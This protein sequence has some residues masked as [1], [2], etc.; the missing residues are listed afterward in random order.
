MIKDH[1]QLLPFHICNNLECEIHFGLIKLKGQ[2]R[3]LF[4]NETIPRIELNY[5]IF[6]VRLK[7]LYVGNSWIYILSLDPSLHPGCVSSCLLSG[8]TWPC[9]E[10]YSLTRSEINSWT[11]H[12]VC[13]SCCRSHLSKWWTPFFQLLRPKAKSSLTH[14]LFSYAP[15]SH[16][17]A[18]PVVTHSRLSWEFSHFVTIITTMNKTP[19]SSPSLAPLPCSLC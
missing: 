7:C 15:Q 17:S 3:I 5:I 12:R 6:S 18:H 11:F 1:P 13:L 4:K 14:L 16:Q 8:S 9:H 10:H 2:I 19:L